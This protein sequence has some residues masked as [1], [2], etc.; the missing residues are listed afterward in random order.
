MQRI[1]I[2]SRRSARTVPTHRSAYAFAPGTALT[3]L[4]RQQQAVLVYLGITADS[5]A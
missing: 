1:R 2:Q 5:Y 3:A 4:P